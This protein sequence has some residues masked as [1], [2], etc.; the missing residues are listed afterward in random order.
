M[1]HSHD[2]LNP[3]SH[4]PHPNPPSADPNFI[5]QLPGQPNEQINPAMLVALP[6]TSLPQQMILSTGHPATGPF[7]FAGVTLLDFLRSRLDLA[8]PAFTVEVVSGDGFGT[9]VRGV[10]VLTPDP[11]GPILLADSLDGGPMSRRQGLVRLLVPSEKDD[12]LRQV[13]WIGE[14]RVFSHD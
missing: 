11:A 8:S 6:R 4:E 9:R 1:S 7:D 10:E 5:L 12:A 3:H 2:P 14:I 13:K